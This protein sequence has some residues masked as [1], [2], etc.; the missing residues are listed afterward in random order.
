L[1]GEVSD[2]GSQK[3]GKLQVHGEKQ[4]CEDDSRTPAHKDISKH[5][6]LAFPGEPWIH[7]SL[8]RGIGRDKF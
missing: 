2:S 1:R 8:I 7:N 4:R 3:F 6:L 5:Q